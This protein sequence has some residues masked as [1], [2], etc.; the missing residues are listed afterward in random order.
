MLAYVELIQR[1]E[2]ELKCD[3]LTHQK[4]S[5]NCFGCRCVANSMTGVGLDMSMAC[6]PVSLLVA[7]RTQ[8]VTFL[9]AVMSGSSS[10]SGMGSDSTEHTF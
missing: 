6:Y 9:L 2:K 8:L 3:V 1:K 4:W 5:L 7:E 10:T